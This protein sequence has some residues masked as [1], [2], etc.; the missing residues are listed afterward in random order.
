MRIMNEFNR[1]KGMPMDRK[2]NLA[3]VL[4]IAVRIEE[5]GSRFYKKA[6]ELETNEDLSK[7]FERLSKEEL[8]HAQSYRQKKEQLGE[9][10]DLFHTELSKEIE[11]F[12]HFTLKG[13]F[14]DLEVG[15]QYFTKPHSSVE[16][17]QTAIDMENRS[18]SFYAALR[19]SAANPETRKMINGIMNEE[20]FHVVRLG[21]RLEMHL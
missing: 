2:I 10:E 13:D 14:F 1:G 15:K 17:I 18:I 7:M 9:T 5:E 6:A 16:I 3:D 12:I 4:D 8:A 19:Q 11:E 20:L 21:K